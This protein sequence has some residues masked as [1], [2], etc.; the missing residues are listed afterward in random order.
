M[1][2]NLAMRRFTACA[3][4]GFSGKHAQ[5]LPVRGKLEFPLDVATAHVEALEQLEQSFLR[6]VYGHFRCPPKPM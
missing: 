3:R 4:D 1:I 2:A 6:V 5:H